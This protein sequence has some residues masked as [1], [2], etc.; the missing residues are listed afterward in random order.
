MPNRKVLFIRHA[1]GYH[2]VAVRENGDDA[3]HREELFDASLTEHGLKECARV[4]KEVQEKYGNVDII[5]VSPLM[6]T[7]QSAT[8]VFRYQLETDAAPQMV[9]MDELRERCGLHPCDR[10]RAV[11]DLKPIFPNVVFSRITTDEDTMWNIKRETFEA[12]TDRVDRALSFLRTRSESLI[13]VVS[14]NDFLY[15]VQER[16]GMEA[17]VLVNLEVLE[18]DM[19]D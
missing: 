12:L 4:G 3:Y 2:N 1:E 16:L 8:C 10:R 6:R 9:A 14:H 13:V 7:L 17:R 18:V 19:S 5:F 15:R 11:T